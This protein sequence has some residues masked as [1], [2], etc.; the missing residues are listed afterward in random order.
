MVGEALDELRGA[1]AALGELHQ[2]RH[3]LEVLGRL[4]RT[5]PGARRRTGVLPAATTRAVEGLATGDAEGDPELVELFGGAWKASKRDDRG[6][7]SLSEV[8]E[9]AG[10]HRRGQDHRQAGVG[11]QLS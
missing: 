10:D 6:F 7:A 2:G 4:A 8:G 9:R 1:V 11:R 5:E 3:P